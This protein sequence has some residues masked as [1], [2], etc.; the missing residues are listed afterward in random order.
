MEHGEIRV[1]RINSNDDMDFSD[2]WIISM[3]D[4]FNGYIPKILL[5]Y[6]NNVLITCGHDGNLFTFEINDEN[7]NYEHKIP[8]PEKGEIL[9]SFCLNCKIL[10]LIN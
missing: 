5:S 3:H 4:N 8:V 7:S 10:T 1:C 9:V 6:N 2:Y